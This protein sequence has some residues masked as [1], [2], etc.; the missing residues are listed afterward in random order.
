MN[1]NLRIYG[2]V[3]T[4]FV[5]GLVVVVRDIKAFL[6]RDFRT[7]SSNL[8]HQKS[9]SNSAYPSVH[10]GQKRRCTTAMDTIH[11]L[12]VAL[13]NAFTSHGQHHSQQELFDELMVHK[14]RLS[15]VFDVGNRNPQEQKEIESG[16]CYCPCYVV[17]LLTT[18]PTTARQDCH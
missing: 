11:R 14:S 10:C 4:S 2:A 5:V 1:T 3:E 8:H 13:V 18:K 17:P 6:T 12:R 7:R 16:E 15:K 9:F